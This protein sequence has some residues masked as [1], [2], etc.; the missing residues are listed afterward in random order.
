MNKQ[1]YEAAIDATALRTD[2]DMLSGG[3]QT[4][5][6]G[7]FILIQANFQIQFKISY[8]FI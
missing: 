5:I 8:I 2:L 7:R 4:E 1:E 3:D 6:G